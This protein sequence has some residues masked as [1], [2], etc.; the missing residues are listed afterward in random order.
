MVVKFIPDFILNFFLLNDEKKI[1]LNVLISNI[2]LFVLIMFMQHLT[3]LLSNLPVFCVF[4]KILGIP[5]PGCGI[6]RSFIAISKLDLVSALKYNP[7]GIIIV[8]FVI[9]QIIVRFFVIF[10]EDVFKRINLYSKF[11]NIIVYSALITVWIIK[12][13]SLL[14]ER[15]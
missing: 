12:V 13:N 5:C 3:I 6:I 1:N 15:R 14:I 11:T 7:V 2:M 10:K 4:Q 8:L 9:I